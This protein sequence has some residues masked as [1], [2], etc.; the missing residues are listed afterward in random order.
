M[1]DVAVERI[2]VSG[3]AGVASA[4][5]VYLQQQESAAVAAV[6]AAAAAIAVAVRANRIAMAV[7]RGIG[8]DYLLLVAVAVLRRISHQMRLTAL[9]CFIGRRGESMKENGL[10]SFSRMLQLS[11][12]NGA[13][14]H[15]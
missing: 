11:Q 13:A 3:K 8:K 1:L 10:L 6:A 5:A 2:T 9:T 4:V 7:G 15:L 12:M 14:R